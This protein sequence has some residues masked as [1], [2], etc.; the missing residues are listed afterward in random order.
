MKT[1]IDEKLVEKFKS[2]D[3][4]AILDTSTGGLIH[5]L[6]DVNSEIGNLLK[7]LFSNY[8]NKV[9]DIT[10]FN[11]F[12]LDTDHMKIIVAYLT[13]YEYLI[14]DP[15]EEEK[16]QIEVS[17]EEE[18][19]EINDYDISK[20]DNTDIFYNDPVKAYIREIGKIELLST[21]EEQK[22]FKKYEAACEEYDNLLEAKKLNF[23]PNFDETKLKELENKKKA[24]KDFLVKS[25]LRLVV[26]IA[27]RYIGTGL[28][29]LDL[30]EEGNIG[31]ISAVDKFDPSKGYKF[32][33]YAT[34]W[35]RQA[36]TRAIADKANIIRKP[37]HLI[38]REQ[39]V[40]R[41]IR[42]QENNN[43]HVTQEEIM[44]KFNLNEE[45]YNYI[46]SPAP[47]SLETTVGEDEDSYL[48]DFIESDIN[49]EHET[50]LALL[51]EDVQE[52]LTCLNDRERFVIEQR[53]GIG[54]DAPKTLEE[55]GRE[56]KV[57]R[58]RIRQIEAKA[59]RKL[60]HPQ[61]KKLLG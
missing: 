25:N 38:E 42:E 57:T 16:D 33:T 2:M 41:Y 46:V 13:I 9:V 1:K 4:K 14:F 56:L 5:K 44:E 59:I 15:N 58:E 3:V 24:L 12:D 11:R 37:V 22:Y 45:Q 52:A 43:K 47:I 26:S 51:K 10:D 8:N 60:R 53:F 27:K 54:Y 30:I 18:N 6:T 19:D 36:V 7:N 20:I 23:E 49:V 28:P 21:E 35:I 34:W 55:V 48:I 17:N 32:S 31:L 40:K 39:K 29:F 61:R 50:Y